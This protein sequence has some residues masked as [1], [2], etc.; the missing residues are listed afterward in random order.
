M[1]I[2]EGRSI[3]WLLNSALHSD[4]QQRR[5]ARAALTP[6]TS[7]RRICAQRVRR[8]E[9]T[10]PLHGGARARPTTPGLRPRWAGDRGINHSARLGPWHSQSPAPG[11]NTCTKPVKEP[12]TTLGVWLDA[13]D[14]SLQQGPTAQQADRP[15]PELGDISRA[16][17]LDHR[18]VPSAPGLRPGTFAASPTPRPAAGRRLGGRVLLAHRPLGPRAVHIHPNLTLSS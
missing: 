10:C 8:A 16:S 2:R 13:A 3:S 15:A 6:G 17:K 4:L 5:L 14:A 11:P 7:R 18:A 12:R 9:H 1:V